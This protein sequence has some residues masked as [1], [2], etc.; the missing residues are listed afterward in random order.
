MKPASAPRI[1]IDMSEATN[2]PPGDSAADKPISLPLAVGVMGLILAVGAGLIWRFL[3]HPPMP[4]NAIRTITPLPGNPR[5]AGSPPAAN[6]SAIPVEALK[7]AVAEADLPDGLHLS[8]G[9][10]TLIKA[11]DAYMRVRDDRFAFG[12]FTLSD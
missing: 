12:Y 10:E 1:F 2:P 5:V 9:G 3:Y 6:D 7:A 11:G 8:R 4:T